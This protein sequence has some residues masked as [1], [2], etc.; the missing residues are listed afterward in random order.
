M[1]ARALGV[2]AIIVLLAAGVAAAIALRGG[3]P[4]ES[5][6]AAATRPN[7]VVIETDDQT[8]A[9]IGVMPNLAS[10]VAGEG[11]TFRHSYV[12]FSLCC[13]SRSTFLT[14]QYVHNHR[15]WG[16]LPPRGGFRRFQRLHGRNNL[17]VWLKRAGYHTAL[18]GK[19]LNGY[20][21][22]HPRQVPRG[23]TEWDS[24]VGA[25][26]Q[27]VYDYDLN[28]NGQLVHYGNAPADFKQDVLT[29]RAVDFIGRRA[30]QAKPFFLWLTY[31]APHASV[32]TPDPSP[33]PP[34]DCGDAPQPAPR[35]AGAF[36][37]TPLP[38]NPDFNEAD[39]SDK[40][41]FI[42][43]QHRLTP[44]R[45][46]D[47][48]R[49]YRCELASLLSVDDGVKRVVDALDSSDELANTYLIFT[50]DN[51]QLHG[52]HRIPIGKGR[53][54]EESIRVPLEIRGPGVPHGRVSQA[55]AINADLAPTIARIAH[56][57]PGLK[58]D[59]RS[60]LGVA[61][62]PRRKLRRTLEIEQP[63]Y[64]GLPAFRGVHTHRYV[65][66]RYSTGEKE[67]YDT[68]RDPWELH[69][70]A[71]AHAFRRVRHRLAA[72]LR[73]LRDCKGRSCRGRLG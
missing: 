43:S 40:P 60:L 49:Y 54:Y 67:L 70:K 33:Q 26:A 22:R 62:H 50:S 58:L 21:G 24:G 46:A 11:V 41:K 53:A 1:Q 51:G 15:V 20:G 36:D 61:K 12:N 8:Q 17:A 7:V 52:E 63:R 19:Y 34:A 10:L 6:A 13:P 71:H 38:M 45:I 57:R 42:R 3:A 72:R 25:G 29:D 18:I 31:T 64:I 5:T 35:H 73:R 27:A 39:V 68:V 32:G 30:P 69:N 9:S 66:V 16:N 47:L 56:A 2:R 23:W 59:G 37:S 4:H 65:Y 55:L 14:G 44:A 28:Q 48:G